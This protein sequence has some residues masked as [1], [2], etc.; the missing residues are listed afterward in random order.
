MLFLFLPLNPGDGPCFPEV[1]SGALGSLIIFTLPDFGDGVF[2]SLPLVPS[3]PNIRSL[4]AAYR[5]S[6]SCMDSPGGGVVVGV[7]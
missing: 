7:L 3:E 6:R 4:A 2:L 1:G 5:A